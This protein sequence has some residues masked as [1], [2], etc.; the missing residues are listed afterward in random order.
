MLLR[1]NSGKAGKSSSNNISWV[2]STQHFSDGIANA[3]Y[4]QDSPH[5]CTRNYALAFLS[6]L[7]KYLASTKLANNTMGQCTAIQVYSD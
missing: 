7:D 3:K 1:A 6:W 2:V 5:S 4:L